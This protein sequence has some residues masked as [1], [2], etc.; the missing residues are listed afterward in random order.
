MTIKR[1]AM[2]IPQW[3]VPRG[4]PPA[5]DDFAVDMKKLT[6]AW[7]TYLENSEIDKNAIYGYLETVFNVVQKWKQ[8]GVAEEYSL[9]ALKDHAW[10]IIKMKPDPFARVIYCTSDA[11]KVTPQ[12]RSKWA[13][14]MQWVAK[15]NRGGKSFTEFVTE[16][17]GLNKC[18]EDAR[19]DKVP[20]LN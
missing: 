5:I 16:K 12:T 19:W 18:A 14:V 7:K 6:K 8:R 20:S 2:T 9:R 13:L 1:R 17:G 11:N 3:R 10:P 4:R 15:H